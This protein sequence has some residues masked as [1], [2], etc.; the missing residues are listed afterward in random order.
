VVPDEIDAQAAVRVRP[1][2]DGDWDLLAAPFSHAFFRVFPFSVMDD[3]ERCDAG[4][5]CLRH[6]RDSGDGPVVLSAC[7]VATDDERPVAA[8][9]VTLWPDRDLS[10]WNAGDWPEPPPPDCLQKRLGIPHLT[11]IFVDPI[12]QGYGVG[13]ALLSA[14]VNRLLDMGYDRLSSTFLQGNDSSLLWHWRNGFELLENPGS[15]RRMQ[16]QISELRTA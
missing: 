9:L 2:R 1:L 3:D 6:T 12:V 7:F 11:W 15:R 16:R 5:Q 4:G 10:D 14:L 8:T 13:T